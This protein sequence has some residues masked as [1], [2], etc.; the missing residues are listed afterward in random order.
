MR[1]EVGGMNE[2][3]ERRFD[4]LAL[5]AGR[6]GL[7]GRG[8]VKTPLYFGSVAAVCSRRANQ[9]PRFV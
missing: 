7:E 2:V 1:M 9:P 6:T 5:P 4:K 8:G 3:D